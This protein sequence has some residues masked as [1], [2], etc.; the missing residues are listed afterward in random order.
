MS[1]DFY[2]A[3]L[4]RNLVR[5]GAFGYRE[6]AAL[7]LLLDAARNA[8]RR[9]DRDPGSAVNFMAFPDF[10]RKPETRP[11]VLSSGRFRLRALTVTVLGKPPLAGPLPL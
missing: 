2:P 11:Q 3:S 5:A 9:Q 7:R 6:N 1:S 8:V 10:G 4:S